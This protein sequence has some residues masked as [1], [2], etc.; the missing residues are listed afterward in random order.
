MSMDTFDRK[1]GLQIT[2]PKKIKKALT[3]DDGEWYSIKADPMRDID[4]W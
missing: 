4:C 2:M 3:K 1:I